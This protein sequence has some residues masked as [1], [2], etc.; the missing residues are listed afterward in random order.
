VEFEPLKLNVD[1]DQFWIA[2]IGNRVVERRLIKLVGLE[3]KLRP[4]TY[5]VGRG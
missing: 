3:F 5:K 1:V 2:A 4:M